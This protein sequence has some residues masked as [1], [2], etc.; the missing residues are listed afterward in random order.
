[1]ITAGQILDLSPCYGW[2]Q[3]RL[4]RVLA[5]LPAP[6]SAI[7]RCDSIP[8]GDR[9]C[10]GVRLATPAAKAA[11]LDVIVRR[12]VSRQTLGD[13][14]PEWSAWAT[15]WLDGTDRSPA[16]AATAATAAATAA[17]A[18]VGVDA[19]E[20]VAKAL[21]AQRAAR[22]ARAVQLAP[23]VAWEDAAWTAAMAAT[24]AE[25]DAE[26][27]QQCLDLAAACDTVDA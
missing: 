14:C 8:V 6:V 1:M 22:A 17:A 20:D 26:R 10:V 18:A 27:S 19:W 23:T 21:T 15:R 12:A 4:G 25:W 13:K 24:N 9:L 11:A 2:S 7:L 16:A 5:I 3:P